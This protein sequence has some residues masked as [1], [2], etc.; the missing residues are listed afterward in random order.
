MLD[1]RVAKK[2]S[3]KEAFMISRRRR[4]IGWMAWGL[5]LLSSVYGSADASVHLRFEEMGPS[6][7]RAFSLRV[8]DEETRAEVERIEISAVQDETFSITV[9]GLVS[10]HSYRV[11]FF[12]DLNENGRYDPPP[13]D[14]AWRM[15]LPNVESGD[16]MV[17]A[18]TSEFIDIGWPP[19]IDGV[20]E[21]GNYSHSLL[22]SETGMTVFWSND[23]ELLHIGLVSPGR[24]WLAIGF[25]PE[26]R[27][28]GA[29]I[30]IAAI[31]EGELL[32]EDHYGSS[33][34]A[35]RE[36]DVDHC[37]QA[38]GSL[39]EEGVV[40]EFAIP[41]D[42]GD[43]QDA[44]LEPG[45]DVTVILAYQS[46]QNDFRARHTRRSTVILTLESEDP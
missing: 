40:L 13:T 41:L 16:E 44:V 5:V 19:L 20:I 38:A 30:I 18:F 27:M 22:D 21:E 17:F 34:T 2:K 4:I 12:A 15:L 3:P 26:R 35:H 25:A 6:I 23:D 45:M 14:A 31:A 42:S 32:I 1:G 10:G 8:V 43:P 46:T 36:D 29:N 28:L 9:D 11:D 33:P 7:G 39:L 24:G 37:L